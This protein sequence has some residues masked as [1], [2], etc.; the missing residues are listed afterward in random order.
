M[1]EFI[2]RFKIIISINLLYQSGDCGI[3][4]GASALYAKDPSS[5][6]PASKTYYIFFN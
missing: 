2:L 1:A 5:Y 4:S 6:S 3:E